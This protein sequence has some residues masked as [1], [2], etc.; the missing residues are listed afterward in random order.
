MS[1]ADAIKTCL[2]KYADFSGRARRSEYWFWV[3]FTVIVDIVSR[4]LDGIAGDGMLISTL[5]GL[6]LLLPSIAVAVRRLH[7]TG[8][9]GKWFLLVFAIV[10]GWIFLIIWFCED[11][12]ADNEYGPN[13]KGAVGYGTAPA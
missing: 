2:S 12:Q 11:S 6:A 3:L 10:V 7:D 13:P 9:S 1:F 5:T 4:A 8:R